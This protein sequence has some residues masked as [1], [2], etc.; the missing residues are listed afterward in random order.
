MCSPLT[1]VRNNYV[2]KKVVDGALCVESVK[3]CAISHKHVDL[4]KLKHRSLGQRMKFCTRIGESGF[5]LVFFT[6]SRKGSTTVQRDPFL[7][8]HL[9]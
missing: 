7:S 2:S 1:H 3:Q 8:S 4:R 6:A 5:V 9:K